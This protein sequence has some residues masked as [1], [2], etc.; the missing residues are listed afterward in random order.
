VDDH[1]IGRSLRALRLRAGLRQ[2]D[3]AQ[4][5]GVSQSLVSTIEGGRP[6]TVTLETLRRVFAAVGAG[7]AG[8]VLWRG[9]ALER[10]LDAR[11]AALVDASAIR[12]RG[13]GWDVMAE[14][15]YSSYGERGSIDLLGTR[16]DRGAVVVEEVKSEL[17]R[18]E[19]TLR[20]L[21]E[22]ARL[23]GSDVGRD[24]LGWTPRVVGRVLVLPDTDRARR[25]VAGHAAVFD[26][27]LPARGPALRAWLRD[28]EGPI[29][30]IL[31]VADIDRDGRN[32][33]RPGAQ[34]VR[35]SWSGRNSRERP[36]G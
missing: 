11:H 29:A 32:A 26:A 19:E 34:R 13:W 15:T 2:V 36:S 23:I 9:P 4:R 21:D 20:K 33:V 8:Q 31:F 3:V 6:A 10:L 16:A 30:G 14:V 28:P 18:V 1:R 5:A 22:K 7:F 25:Q 27:A 17:A 12:L 24:R 35:V